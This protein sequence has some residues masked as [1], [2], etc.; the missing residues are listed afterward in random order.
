MKRLGILVI[1]L[2]LFA[3]S[4]AATEP[5]TVS[6]A[7]MSRYRENEIMEYQGARLDPA[8]GPR[9]N[10]INGVQQVDIETYT[11]V[12]NGLVDTPQ[13]LTYDEVLALP[14]Y[15]RLITLHC[16]EGWDATILWKGVLLQDLMDLAGVQPEA[17]TVIFSAVD[18]Y[19]TSLPLQT[20]LDK[21][22]ILAYDANG[23]Q[24]PPE[25]G[26]PFIV[27]AEDKLGYKWARWVDKI[28]LSDDANY[29]GFW[30]G[31]GYSNDASVEGGGRD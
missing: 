27:V 23:I 4:C 31:V 8:V 2:L 10:S 22:L 3:S 12:I 7:T 17:V 29:E 6:S 24:L 9:D 14:E 16:V 21:Q 30:E 20:V 25:M 18:G 15:E 5:D 26:Y 19:T 1:T 11:L 28:T 13:E